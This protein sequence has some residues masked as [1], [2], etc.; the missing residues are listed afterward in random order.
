MNIFKRMSR[1]LAEAGPTSQAGSVSGLRPKITGVMR[2]YRHVVADRLAV[3]QCQ[4]K[5]IGD[6]TT[7]TQK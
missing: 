6:G 2:C 3:K 7:V 1:T 4:P 5:M